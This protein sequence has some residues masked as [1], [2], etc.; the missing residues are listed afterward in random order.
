M[1]L[2]S[3]LSFGG[4]ALAGNEALEALL[5]TVGERRARDGGRHRLTERGIVRA[6]SIAANCGGRPLDD[7]QRRIAAVVRFLLTK[8]DGSVWS[9]QLREPRLRARLVP[10]DEVRKAR[11]HSDGQP[12]SLLCLTSAVRPTRLQLVS[13]RQD[14]TVRPF[15]CCQGV[16][17]A[18]TTLVKT[19]RDELSMPITLPLRRVRGRSRSRRAAKRLSLGVS[20]PMP[21]SG[22][23]VRCPPRPLITGRKPRTIDQGKRPLVFRLPLR[24]PMAAAGAARTLQRTAL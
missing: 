15:S 11:F 21:G 14:D 5:N 9:H 18:V 19:L 8:P 3:K 20:G 22:R 12:P 7:L 16:R 17:N 10:V 6:N 23:R 2:R 13:N 24:N 4:Q 1:E